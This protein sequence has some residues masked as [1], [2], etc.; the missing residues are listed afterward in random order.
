MQQVTTYCN[1][2]WKWENCKKS[3]TKA[4]KT[5]VWTPQSKRSG[6]TLACH[7]LQEFWSDIKSLKEIMINTNFSLATTAAFGHFKRQPITFLC[8]WKTSR[9]L[10][11]KKA[12]GAEDSGSGDLWIISSLALKL[13]HTSTT[14]NP[15]AEQR[16]EELKRATTK[17]NLKERT[18]H[19][20]L[21]TP[22]Q[23]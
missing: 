15:S 12:K 20:A 3:K 13:Y 5:C 16:N 14:V 9:T 23:A 22:K 6:G 21:T 7:I 1:I 19:C 18:W 11:K 2:S 17:Q 4:V 8:K 10:Q